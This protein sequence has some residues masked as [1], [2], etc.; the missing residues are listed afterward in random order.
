MDKLK[1]QKE[2][3][4]IYETG[5]AYE[6]DIIN[7]WDNLDVAEKLKNHEW[8]FNQEIY[9]KKDDDDITQ[10]DWNSKLDDDIVTTQGHLNVAEKKMGNWDIFKDKK[11]AAAKK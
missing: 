4:V 8:K 6:G 1:K 9:D 3:P 5:Q 11:L 7:T 10:Y 2:P